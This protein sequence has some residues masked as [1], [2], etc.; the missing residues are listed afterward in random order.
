MKQLKYALFL[1]M[2]ALFSC[3]DEEFLIENETNFT[4]E[5]TDEES[6]SSSK[7]IMDSLENAKFLDMKLSGKLNQTSKRSSSPYDLGWGEIQVKESVQVEDNKGFRTTSFRVNP[8]EE[9]QGELYNLV[10]IEKDELTSV[11]IFGYKTDKLNEDFDDGIDLENFSGE[12]I[13]QQLVEI[14]NDLLTDDCHEYLSDLFITE[15]DDNSSGGSSSN[16]GNPGGNPYGGSSGGG[17]FS[18]TVGGGS[19]SG[20][21]DGGS[22]PEYAPIDWSFIGDVGGGIG[23]F[24]GTIG[25]AIS[26]LITIIKNSFPCGC[27]K[28]PLVQQETTSPSLQVNYLLINPDFELDIDHDCFPAVVG[29]LQGRLNVGFIAQGLNLNVNE[30]NTIL[31]DNPELFISMVAVILQGIDAETEILLFKE[32]LLAIN[33]EHISVENAEKLIEFLNNNFS[34]D[35]LDFALELLEIM[36]GNPDF[37]PDFDLSFKSPFNIDL[38]QVTP[39]NNEPEKERFIEV[40]EAVTESSMFKNMIQQTFDENERLN[41]KFEIIENLSSSN[42][43]D[44]AH[45]KAILHMGTLNETEGNEAV[46][47]TIQINKNSLVGSNSVSKIAI[48]KTIMHEFIHAY[49]YIKLINANLGA[50]LEDL[51]NNDLAESLNEYNV[52]LDGNSAT[53]QHEFMFD[54][55]VPILSNNL[56]Q[57]LDLLVPENHQAAAEGTIFDYDVSVKDPRDESFEVATTLP[58]NPWDWQEF[59]YFFSLGGLQNTDAFYNSI[60]LSE[61]HVLYGLYKEYLN[62]GENLFN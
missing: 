31:E 10:V 6:I 17:W 40:Y 52:A 47:I 41:V 19:P 59:Y 60:W 20:G 48:A 5:S 28:R 15:E 14:G 32:L 11:H 7:F 43:N 39:D 3:S 25:E 18:G 34:Q 1:L 44:P 26:D 58:G 62:V 42:T 54:K 37:N 38:T 35:S 33:N 27:G 22:V 55:M 51:N 57:I 36:E 49:I 24:L 16:G 4:T 9:R 29:I 45:G 30:V 2:G 23:D 21:G 56:A 50:S 8:F 46:D 61:N 12:I 13:S 53:T